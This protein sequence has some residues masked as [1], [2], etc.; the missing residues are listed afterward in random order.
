M[1]FVENKIIDEA[2]KVHIRNIFPPIIAERMFKILAERLWQ[3]I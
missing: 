3:S 2:Q 1:I